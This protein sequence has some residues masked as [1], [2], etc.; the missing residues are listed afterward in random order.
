MLDIHEWH[1]LDIW[2]SREESAGHWRAA[3]Q[4]ALLWHKANTM[5]GLRHREIPQVDNNDWTRL[6]NYS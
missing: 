5:F 2:N 1:H 3:E 4:T 6:E